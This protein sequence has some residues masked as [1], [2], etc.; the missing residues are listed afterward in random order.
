MSAPPQAPEVLQNWHLID[1]SGEACDGILQLGI[2]KPGVQRCGSGIENTYLPCLRPWVPSPAPQKKNKT[3]K[4]NPNSR[5]L[6]LSKLGCPRKTLSSCL[7][8][9][10]VWARPP[11]VKGE[12]HLPC[13]D[14]KTKVK[15]MRRRSVI[16]KGAGGTLS[17]EKAKKEKRKTAEQKYNLQTMPDSKLP[18]HLHNSLFYFV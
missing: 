6:W 10:T 5:E 2:Q 1:T 12:P 7:L 15:L 4:A 14:L 16:I 3:F 17:Q 13:S 18:L 9:E 8:A 11:E